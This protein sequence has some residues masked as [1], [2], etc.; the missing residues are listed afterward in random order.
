MRRYS[1]LDCNDLEQR[2]SGM[3]RINEFALRLAATSGS[4]HAVAFTLIMRAI[5]K[6]GVPVNGKNLFASN[7]AGSPTWYEMRVSGRGYAA[8]AS[9]FDLVVAMNPATLDADIADVAHGGCFVFDS[10]RALDDRLRRPDVTLIGIPFMELSASTFGGMSEQTLMRHILLVGAISA[11]IDIDMEVLQR[12]VTERFGKKKRLAEVVQKA[13][14]TG[15]QYT[16]THVDCPLPLRVEAMSKHSETILID[17][18]TAAAMGCLYAAATVAAWYPITP[19]TSLIEGFQSFCKIHRSDPETGQQRVAILDVEDEFAALGVVIGAAWAG[20]RAFTATSGPG[21]SVMNELIGL[22]YYSEVPAVVFIVQRAG[23]STGMPTRTQQSDL[24][25]CAYASHGD[26]RHICLYPADPHEAFDMA[27][28]AFDLADRFQ[29]PVFVLSDLDIGMNEWSVPKFV[30]DD[31]YRPD[32]GKVLTVDELQRLN[33]FSRY[34]DTDGDGIPFRTLPGL[35]AS[36]AHFTRGTGHDRL[37]NPTE[38]G[39]EYV[40]VVDRIDRKI[41][42]AVQSLPKPILRS[43]SPGSLGILTVGG[44]H[45]A[46]LE[47]L[48]LLAEDGI[49]MNYM[50]VRGFPFGEDVGSFIDAAEVVF[51]V[52]QNRHGQLRNMVAIETGRPMKKL[53]SVRHYSGA[54]MTAQHVVSTVKSQLERL[55]KAGS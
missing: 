38:N 40:E 5:F 30:W 41:R 7:I 22:A 11:L 14:D 45:A 42:G 27:V 49:D 54:P 52:E 16:K 39:E 18:N 37:G 28:K 44:C 34:A 20:A 29:T 21:L 8:R 32:R 46:C 31:G 50:R 23:P 48:D 51:V 17:G 55:A 36:G 3:D 43:L 25:A 2:A 12:T 4:G 47:A 9:H 1:D 35:H 53:E 24:M 33:G 15:F 6:M 19:A 10:T 13:I 26:T